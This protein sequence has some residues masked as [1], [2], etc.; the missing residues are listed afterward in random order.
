MKNSIFVLLITVFAFTSCKQAPKSDEAKV[1]TAKEESK[2]SSGE[3]YKADTAESHVEW[4]GTKVSGYHVGTLKIKSGELSV[5]NGEV[6]GGNFI[7]D[8]TTIKA[9]GPENVPPD[10]NAKLTGHLLSAEFFDTGK[11]PEASFVITGVKPFNGTL[12]DADDPRQQHLNKY[13][14]TNPTHT[15]SGNLTVKGITKNIEFPAAITL[16]GNT[17][18]AR[19]K[20]NID[21]KLWDIVYAGK[22]D[23][24]IRDEIHLGILLVAKK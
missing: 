4:I 17:V 5:A 22:P 24:L 16:N 1:T 21:R 7:L 11:Y 13:K 9:V 19:A 14:V 8:M 6:S 18:E 3:T 12:N 23:D 15:V 2:M 10:A 20:F